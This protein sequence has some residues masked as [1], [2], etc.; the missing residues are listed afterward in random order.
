MRVPSIFW[1]IS[2]GIHAVVIGLLGEWGPSP[3]KTLPE[4]PVTPVRL[5]LVSSSGGA[6]GRPSALARPRPAP[7]LR[8]H[9]A[10]ERPPR[11][12]VPRKERAISPAPEPRERGAVSPSPRRPAAPSP[13]PKDPKGR[14]KDSSAPSRAPSRPLTPAPSPASRPSPP[15]RAPSG[16]PQGE[17][18]SR[19]PARPGAS[20]EDRGAVG[21]P[22]RPS[23]GPGGPDGEVATVRGRFPL[24]EASSLR[25]TRQVTPE[26][27]PAS[28][29]RG[30][31]GTVVLI[32]TV[33]GG[34]V[35]HAEVER[36]SGFRALDEAAEKALRR[37]RF[38][39]PGEVRVRIPVAFRLETE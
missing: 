11:R 15:L 24:V 30:E 32:L 31:E 1:L 25:V 22:S 23:P 16:A 17:G 8:P 13:A 14:K 9:P 20:P 38:D 2:L 36:S 21:R 12:L 4:T 35:K 34:R 7:V 10:D 3:A 5:R 28:R 18:L 26:Y 19:S 6:E 39:A 29:R 33:E 37:W 27:P